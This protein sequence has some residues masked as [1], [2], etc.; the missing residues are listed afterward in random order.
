MGKLSH[1]VVSEKHPVLL[2]L[3]SD[4]YSCESTA[5]VL[6]EV[7]VYLKHQGVPWWQSEKTFPSPKP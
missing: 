7:S 6:N 4:L 3:S 5:K 2:L 1:K